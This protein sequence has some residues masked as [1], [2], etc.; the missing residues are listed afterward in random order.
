MWCGLFG[1]KHETRTVHGMHKYRRLHKPRS[2]SSVAPP[3]FYCKVISRQHI[4]ADLHMDLAN[5]LR[6]FLQDMAFRRRHLYYKHTA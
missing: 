5:P 4:R 6:L 3:L 1:G 2:Q